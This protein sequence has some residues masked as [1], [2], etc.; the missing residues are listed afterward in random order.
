M[1]G[2]VQL[3]PF[4]PPQNASTK[5]IIKGQIEQQL[6]SCTNGSAHLLFWEITSNLKS[7]TLTLTPTYTLVGEPWSDDSKILHAFYST[8]VFNTITCL[9]WAMMTGI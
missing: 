5:I 9:L 2:H 8:C 4:P 3:S 7:L 6:S 1:W